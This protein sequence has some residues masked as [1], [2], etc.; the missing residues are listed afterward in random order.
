MK[1]LRKLP[2]IVLLVILFVVIARQSCISNVRNDIDS[3]PKTVFSL[4][5]AQEYF[6]NAK[7][8]NI[9]SIDKAEVIGAKGEIIGHLLSTSPLADT[10]IGYAGKVPV[11]IAIDNKEIIKGVKLICNCNCESPGFIR[12]ID[13]KAFFNS[14][15]GMSL[16]DARTADVDVVSGASMTTAAVKTGVQLRLSKYLETDKTEAPF[17]WAKTLAFA[18]SLFVVILALVSF[19]FAK[20]FAKKRVVLL[21]ASLIIL[22]FWQG[23]LISLALMYGW[24]INGLSLTA[25]TLMLIILVL[26][27][28]LP[29][30]TNKAFYCAH[31]CPYGAAQ[32]LMG[33]ISKKKI[34]LP[35]NF[36]KY[37]KHF[38]ML[39]FYTLVLAVILRFEFDLSDIEPFSA[40]LFTIASPLVIILATVFL[41]I[42]IFIP[43]AW[44]NYF[45]PTG[46]LLDV[47]RKGKI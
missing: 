12:R 25:K 42:S 23:E 30:F 9:L 20:T 6:S 39:F 24:L 29:L 17:P 33:K 26:S 36:I 40:F 37:F 16:R 8:I 45:C 43:K 10:I 32:E 27:L 19:F 31:V 47:F 2:E 1:I 38:K 5:D 28:V 4:V 46:Y 35:S 13:K 14:W 15:D 11:L 41:I 18:A 21:I 44:C 7:D 34:K 3:E 22:G